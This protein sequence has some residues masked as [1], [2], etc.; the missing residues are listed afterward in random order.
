MMIYSSVPPPKCGT[1][2]TQAIFAMLIFGKVEHGLKPGIISPWIDAQL[3]PI[4]E[5]L[6]KVESQ[7]HRRFIKTQYSTRWYPLFLIMYLHSSA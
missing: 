7:E 6:E 4:D 5:Y 2:W 1:T 3:A